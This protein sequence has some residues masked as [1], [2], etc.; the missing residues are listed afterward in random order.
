M[1]YYEHHIGDYAE[2]TAHL[3]FIEDAAYSRMIRKYYATEKPLPAD[4]KAVQRL[5]GARTKEEREAVATVL[6]EFFTL[7][8][9]GWHN[10]RCDEDIAR[11]R[12]GDAEREQKAAHEKERMR[13]YREER[14]NIFSELRKH[15][16]VPKWD[17]SVAQL[18]EL[19]QRTCNA[20][21]T[22][23]GTEQKRTC[24]A[25]ATANQTPD[26]RHQT[27]KD[28]SEVEQP[29][30]QAPT[31]AGAICSRLMK[32]GTTGVNPHHPKLLALL[33][34][35]IT[36][37]EIVSAA[38]EPASKGKGL[39]WLLAK[40]EGRRRDS[41][42]ENLPAKYEKP[43]F[44]SSPGIETKAKELGIAQ[45]PGEVWVTFRNRVYA[46]AG[47]TDEMIRKAKIDAGE[48]V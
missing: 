30:A 36:E 24:N 26:T 6:E 46:E 35:G 37:E 23:T 42:V 28:K 22:R 48:K 25:P 3:S 43:W 19:L 17:T 40:V 2:A 29:P 10:A 31:P 12:E 20:P 38:E 45:E 47:V 32:I 7:A 41:A 15:G 21:A 5:I 27:P 39:A 18:R 4:I 1:N 16:I 34:A 14:S 13:R 33:K 8:A 11:Y 44:M 9:D